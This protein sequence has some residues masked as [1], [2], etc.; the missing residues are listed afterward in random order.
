MSYKLATAYV[1]IQAR[2]SG[3]MAALGQLKS[4][5]GG[6]L[7]GISNINPLVAAVAGVASMTFAVRQLM[8]ES[9]DGALAVTRLNAILR[10]TGNVAKLSSQEVIEFAAQ[11][12]KEGTFGDTSIISAANKLIQLGVVTKDTYKDILRLSTDVARAG[13]GSVEHAAMTLGRA[14]SDPA[15]GMRRLRSIG[16]AFTKA[17]QDK[18]KALMASNNLLAAQSEIIEKVRRSVGGLDA[19]WSKKPQGVWDKAKEALASIAQDLGDKIFPIIADLGKELVAIAGPL[20]KISGYVMDINQVLGGWPLKLLIIGAAAK[21]AFSAFGLIRGAVIAN[22][23][24]ITKMGMAL[25]ALWVGRM[26]PIMG[27]MLQ[28]PSLLARIGLAWKALAAAITTGTLFTG[29]GAV[30]VA[31]GAILV[32]VV[33]LGV[34]LSR[35]PKVSE[36]WGRMLKAASVFFETMWT[37]ADQLWRAL[38]RIITVILEM[39]GDI[40]GLRDLFN[41]GLVGAAVFALDTITHSILRT[42]AYITVL[43]SHLADVARLM[44]AI[45]T[46]DFFGMA[47]AIGKLSTVNTDAVIEYQRL[48]TEMNKMSKANAITPDA[49]GVAESMDAFDKTKSPLMGLQQAWKNVQESILSKASPEEKM[50]NGIK[51]L[52]GINQDQLEAQQETNRLLA[53]GGAVA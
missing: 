29:W 11:L 30:L 34:Y 3:V 41:N 28:M 52:E 1:D 33:S 48:V 26:V 43:K 36:A 7:T 38:G 25:R 46:R 16:I 39:H 21:A 9:E 31:I 37:A 4:A 13:F 5:L 19:E 18:I 27:G 32:A 47:S 49:D 8:Q 40:L 35:F 14:L 10:A 50:A 2:T 24:E 23:A 17:E 42:T 22:I 20:A 53:A 6:M 44:L 51:N 15:S 12:Q 45:Q